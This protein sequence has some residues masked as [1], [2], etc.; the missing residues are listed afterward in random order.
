MRIIIFLFFHYVYNYIKCLIGSELTHLN[1]FKKEPIEAVTQYYRYHIHGDNIVECERAFDLIKD[2]LADHITSISGPNGSPVCPEYQFNLN[3]K[4]NQY[5][6]TFYPGFGR[7]NNDILQLV[8]ERGGILREAADVII[9]RVMPT[10]EEP[11]IAIEYCGALPAGNQA[12]QRSGRAYSFGQAHIPYIY[13][14]ELGGYELDANRNRK[15]PRMPNPAVP[16]SYLSY[17]LEQAASVFPVFVTSPGADETSRKVYVTEFADAEL[18]AITRA[19]LLGNNPSKIEKM[20]RQK[21]LSFIQKRAAKS[22]SGRTLTPMQWANAYICLKK[23]DTLVNFL[24]QHASLCW[25]KKT[26]IVLT[27]TMKKLM[28]ASSKLAI[29]LTSTD[30]PICIVPSKKRAEFA[31]YVSTLYSNLPKD[32]VQWLGRKKHLTICWVAGFKPGGDDARPDRGLPPFTRMLIGEEQDLLT[33]VYGPAPK[34]TWPVLQDNPSA[35]AKRNGLWEAILAVSNGLLVDSTTDKV[36]NHGF[37]KSHWSASTHKIKSHKMLVSPKPTRIGENDV[38]TVLHSLLARY[39]GDEVFE[40]MCNPPGGDWSGV[41]LLPANRSLELRWLTLPRVSGKEKKRPDHVFQLFID[42]SKPII[43]SVESKETASSV[44]ADIGPRL[45][46]Y[47][48]NLIASPASVERVGQKPW[49]HSTRKLDPNKFI[50]ASGAAFI[51]SSESKIYSVIKKANVDIVL[52]YT[53][54]GAGRSC[55]IR[56]IPNGKT[57]EVICNYIANLDLSKTNISIVLNQ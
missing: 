28:T 24:T 49:T 15:A 2:S 36:T 9:T 42:G 33:V 51:S 32:F 29:G 31:S 47:I 11:L 3:T 39:A 20:L 13:V 37:L 18:V 27:G 46:S 43:F 35:L 54:Q 53:F 21:I 1:K 5:H 34:T 12:W 17:S 14:A 30:L 4:T 57:G 6:F 40:G 22:R 7:W 52:A 44:E 48:T 41:S 19:I 10:Y 45:S 50:F 56:L 26:S 25:S 8:R 23:G 38:D 55:E 16:F